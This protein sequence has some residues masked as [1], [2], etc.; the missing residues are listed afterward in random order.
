M[1]L[2]KKKGKNKPDL[3]LPHTDHGHDTT[4]GT[5]RRVR[6]TAVDASRLAIDIG[7]EASDA[8]GPL[9]SAL[10][11][12]KKITELSEVCYAFCSIVVQSIRLLKCSLSQN[13][14]ALK[15]SIATLRL[16]VQDYSEWL[17]T[18]DVQPLKLPDRQLYKMECI[19]RSIHLCFYD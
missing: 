11:A 3:G 16:D 18:L 10:G 5:L 8:C 19:R 7:Y 9:K 4:I 6:Q 2:H 14:S 17:D 13:S 12:V 1:R 15:E